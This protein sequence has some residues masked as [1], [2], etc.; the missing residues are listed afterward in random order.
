VNLRA[1]ASAV[2]PLAKCDLPRSLMQ[3]NYVASGVEA[4]EPGAA[5][6]PVL[7]RRG[8]GRGRVD[9]AYRP[10]AYGPEAPVPAPPLYVAA[11]AD[12]DPDRVR[13]AGQRIVATARRVV[14]DLDNLPPDVQHG[15]ES[16]A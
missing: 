6:L 2:G 7:L 8:R 12:G 11:C 10:G 5:G 9:R 3:P 16:V 15:V 1:D 4:N 14:E 13:P